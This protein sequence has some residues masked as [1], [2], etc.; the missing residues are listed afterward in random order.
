MSLTT[1]DLARIAGVSQST[2]SRSLNDSPLISKETKERIL[3]LAKEYGFVFNANARSLITNRTDTIGII[4]PEDFMD[5]N[6]NLYFGAFH[7]QVQKFLEKKSKN[8][9]EAF[10]YNRFTGKSNIEELVTSRK[11]DGLLLACSILPPET[12]QFLSRTQIPYVFLH[13]F[14]EDEDF[15]NV[16]KV[17]NDNLTGGDIA[18]EHLI[19]LCHKKIITVTADYAEG[20][21]YKLRT[22]G[23]LSALHDYGIPR[24]NAIVLKGAKRYFH[25]GYDAVMK[26]QKIIRRTTAI[27]AQ[28]D[29]TALGVIEALRELTIRVPEDIALVG[30]DNVEI[31]TYFKPYLTTVHQPR[32]QL[33]VLACQ[34]LLKKI[35]SKEPV[36]S[37]VIKLL[38]TLVVRESCGAYLKKS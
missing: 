15:S 8:L 31:S 18:T 3:R 24:E 12:K 1:K 21:E 32:E 26:N 5:F 11:V 6:A 16:D 14:V 2:I 20:N 27:F 7:A 19:K 17:Y 4:Y 37:Q 35:S 25:S 9:I 22:E 34:Q 33:A 28:N 30:F 23:Y 13:H 10:S 36:K 38:P 29:M